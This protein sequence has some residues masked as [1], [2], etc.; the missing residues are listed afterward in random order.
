M[1]P[2]PTMLSLTLVGWTIEVDNAFELRMPHRTTASRQ[3]GEA[4]HGPWLVSFPMYVHCIRHLPA[5]GIAQ[6]ELEARA[7]VLGPV[8]GLERWGYVTV[9]QPSSQGKQ[10]ADR[11]AAVVRP[12]AAAI[13]AQSVWAALPDEVDARWNARYGKA[14]LRALRDALIEIAADLDGE[15]PDYLPGIWG[16]GGLKNLLPG[17]DR[18][19]A[20][21]RSSKPRR[22]ETSVGPASLPLYALLSKVLLAFAL[23]FEGE[24]ELSLAL[25]ANV[26]RVLDQVGVEVPDLPRSAGVS[27]VAVAQSLTRLKHHVLVDNAPGKRVRRAVLTPRGLASQQT[28]LALI[29]NIERRWVRR[30]GSDVLRRLRSALEAIVVTADLAGS[31]LVAAYGPLPGTW[32]AEIPIPDTLPHYPMVLHRGGY[33][34]GA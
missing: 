31:P 21:Y 22:S 28:Y 13:Q 2:L 33:P 34:D 15:L 7:R 30:L 4:R 8:S 12:T 18:L 24:A 25:S 5:A 16:F 3:R 32:R 1:I 14:T 17:D 23:E 9:T 29:G 10:K 11:G 26:L 20:R 6:R 19:P 27:K